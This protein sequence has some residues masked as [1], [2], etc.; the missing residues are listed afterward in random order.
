MKK[1]FAFAI[2]LFLLENA[3]AQFSGRVLYEESYNSKTAEIS[4][5]DL[6]KF[7]GTKRELY[8]KGPFYKHVHNGV[9]KSVMLYR[10]DENK[11]YRFNE[12]ADTILWM[13]ASRDTLSKISATKIE[14]SKEVIL[15][16]K[17]KKIEVKTPLGTT[18]YYFNDAYGI[19]PQDFENHRIEYW[20]FYTS[21]ARAIPLKIVFEGKEI[22]LVSTAIKIDSMKFDSKTFDVP[23]GYLKKLF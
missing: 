23:L 1:L 9:F 17:C 22:S 3:K 16:L 11:L 20:D 8:I 6:E 18:T 10:G 21:V 13:D 4:V 5:S 2:I 12:G 19:N 7:I 14:S 15:G